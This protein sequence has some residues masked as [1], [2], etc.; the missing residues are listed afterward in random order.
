[1]ITV[2]WCGELSCDIAAVRW[3]GIDGMRTWARS[4]RGYLRQLRFKTSH[5][6]L[7]RILTPMTHPPLSMRTAIAASAVRQPR[8]RRAQPRRIAS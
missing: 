4:H 5:Y 6:W 2:R 8:A 1:M 3:T 7:R